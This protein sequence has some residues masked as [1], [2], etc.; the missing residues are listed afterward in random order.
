MAFLAAFFLSALVYTTSSSFNFLAL[1]FFVLATTNILLSCGSLGFLQCLFP[2]FSENIFLFCFSHWSPP[3]LIIY[4]LKVFIPF[5]ALAHFSFFF[6][7]LLVFFLKMESSILKP[8]DF[9]FF[10]LGSLLNLDWSNN[11][12]SLLITIP[13]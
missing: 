13:L 1:S 10:F 8:F 11:I 6:A 4:I 9:F 7:F 2:S 12:F 5:F 3:F